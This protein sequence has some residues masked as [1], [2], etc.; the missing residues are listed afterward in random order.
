MKNKKF[1]LISIFFVMF[2][3]LFVS[4]TDFFSNSWAPWAA[5]NPNKLIP[6]VN[7]G[8]VDDLVSM[9]ENNPDLSLSLLK[10]IQD[11]LDKDMSEED[12]QKL[13]TSAVDAAVNAAG[14][15]QAILGSI[16]DIGSITNADDPAKAA[17]DLLVKALDEMKNVEEA[18][19]VLFESLP[20]PDTDDFVFF[21]ENA[22]VDQ[23][24]MAAV[25]LIAGEMK[26]VGEDD[27]EDYIENLT[28]TSI[29]KDDYKTVELAMA[30]AYIVVVG[31]R[32][33]ELS[34]TLKNVLGGLNLGNIKL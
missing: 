27:L 14:L 33:D 5:R 25:V 13:R 18:G 29:D 21:T 2:T 30:L 20:K 26:K 10:K 15:G 9:A 31:E 32:S 3:V 1:L 11:A 6:A 17:K 23:I 16:D 7:P 12:K 34:D 28:N 22:N 8:N 24:A 19:S 4:C